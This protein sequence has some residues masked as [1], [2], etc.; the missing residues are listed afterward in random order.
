MIALTFCRGAFAAASV[1]CLGACGLTVPDIKESWDAD[2]PANPATG[3]PKISG[4]AQIEFEIKKRIY[5]DLRDAVQA[6][7][8]IEVSAGSYDKPGPAKKGII[9][10]KWG[11]QVSLSLQVDESSAL[12][13]GLTFDDLVSS[14]FSLGLGGTLSSTATR[15]DKFNPSWSIAYLM[16]PD[17]PYSVC[18]PGNDPF[19]QIRWKPAASSPFIL[20]SD[21]GIK[22]WLQG[23]MFTDVLLHS[24]GPAGGDPKPDT[25]SYEI[26]FVIVSSGSVT[27][28]WKLVKFSANTSGDFFSVGRTRTHDLIITIGPNDSTT[29]DAHLASQIGN[30]VSNSNRALLSRR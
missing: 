25:V 5:C 9:P 14:T 7:N 28:T 6:V 30:A 23:A 3:E 4:T 29:L 19:E 12:N 18:K 20:E 17:T 2:R 22:E 10:L 16:R 11:A 24:V 1:L 26:K 27:P 21:L 8:L 13:P 15:V